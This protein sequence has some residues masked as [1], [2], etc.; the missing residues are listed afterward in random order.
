MQLI[1]P[2]LALTAVG[3]LAACEFPP[4]GSDGFPPVG[5][6]GN[7]SVA[8]SGLASMLDNASTSNGVVS[9]SYFTDVVSDGR[10]LS[11]ADTHC[12]GPGQAVITLNKGTKAGRAY[13]T[14]LITCR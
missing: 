7:A 6:G 12:G 9:Y 1:K 3:F 5:G 8:D 2:F 4:N 11:G 10:V 14:M 13:N